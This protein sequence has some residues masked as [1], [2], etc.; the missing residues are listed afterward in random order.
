MW[1]LLFFFVT[2]VQ[3]VSVFFSVMVSIGLSTV[4]FRFACFFLL[5]LQLQLRLYL[6][7]ISLFLPLLF[8]AFKIILISHY[9]H[10][11]M[12]WSCCCF[13]NQL[14]RIKT[15]I[16]YRM[17]RHPFLFCVT[18]FPLVLQVVFVFIEFRIDSAHK[19]SV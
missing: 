13:L 1:L 14:D 19:D 17:H 18:L 16:K 8:T 5:R 4:Y 2:C 3:I 15:V 11:R 9:S 12:A 6:H 7:L 10:S